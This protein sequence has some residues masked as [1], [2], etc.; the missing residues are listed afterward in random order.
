MRGEDGRQVG[1]SWASI[2]IGGM[3]H[4]VRM[5]ALESEWRIHIQLQ[6]IAKAAAFGLGGALLSEMS[7]RESQDTFVGSY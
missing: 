6:R 1:R 4:W 5:G 3:V 7:H 2:D